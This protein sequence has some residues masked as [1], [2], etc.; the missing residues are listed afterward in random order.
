VGGVGLTRLR[1][2]AT[3]H[4][5]LPNVRAVKGGDWV[6]RLVP[7]LAM[8]WLLAGAPGTAHGFTLI[9]TPAIS[10]SPASGLPTAYFRVRGTYTSQGLCTPTAGPIAVLFQFFWDTKLIWKTVIPACNAATFEWDT[11]LSPYLLP[12][13]QQSPG[14][15]VVEVDVY[16]NATGNYLP[17]IR[18]NTPYTLLQA[19][20]SPVPTPSPTPSPS[21][22][23]PPC[24]AEGHTK[25]CPSPSAVDCAHPPTAA[26]PPG[27]AGAGLAGLIVGGALAG[28]LPLVGSALVLFPGLR[29]RRDRWARLAALFG[30][31]S[32][33]LA[34][35]TCAMPNSKAVT[36]PS[37]A[38]ASVAIGALE[39]TPDCRGYWM[40]GSTGGIYPFGN[41]AGF[42]S[43]GNVPLN[44]PIVDMEAT[45]DGGGY[46]L[47][48]SDGGIFPFGNAAGYGSTANIKLSQPIVAMENTPDGAGYWLVSADGAIFPFGD[49]VGHGSTGNAHLNKPIVDM[50]ATPD[51]GG[52]WLVASDGG[53]FP[54]GDAVGFGSPGNVQVK[55]PIVGMEATPSGHGYWLVGSDG[56]IFLF[57]DAVGY[58]STGAAH[59]VSPIV[60]MEATP[61]G[62]GYWLVAA[63]GGVFPFGDAPGLGS[64]AGH[65]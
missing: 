29:R 8:A 26:L 21:P 6:R 27:T 24:Y 58:G 22:T 7:A 16:N 53:I 52:Y 23:P 2:P 19:P 36:S 38:A 31:S 64:A 62:H 12:P 33:V 20:P 47:V 4:N 50:E 48:A 43:A 61:D 13:G 59:L 17:G 56:G 15:H 3:I 37:P 14:D 44:K 28:G 57:G 51:G 60:G 41:A 55:A 18:A 54:F 40:A 25:A 5:S 10:I 32:V 45:P 1:G 63:D 11:G 46:W 35:S 39:V 34:L 49:A 30:L 65:L 9:G 42:G